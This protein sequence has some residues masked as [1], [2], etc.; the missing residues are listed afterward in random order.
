M[1]NRTRRVRKGLVFMGGEMYDPNRKPISNFVIGKFLKNSKGN[2]L[3]EINSIRQKGEFL[4]SIGLSLAEYHKLSQ[5]QR[6]Y[7]DSMYNNPALTNNDKKEMEHYYKIYMQKSN[8]G[9]REE[10][11]VYEQ[12]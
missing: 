12:Y 9:K 2:Q 3:K 6:E 4:K 1:R 8:N 5:V 7:I 10:N 11:A